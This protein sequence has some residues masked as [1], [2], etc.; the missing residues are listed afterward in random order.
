MTNCHEM[1]LGEVYVCKD[2]GLELQ[3][4]KECRDQGKPAAECA[5]HDDGGDPCTFSCCGKPLE[6]K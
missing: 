6:K 1:K 3:V 4:V 5:C 2:C